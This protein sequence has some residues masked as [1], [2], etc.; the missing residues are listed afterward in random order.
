MR[1]VV[2]S[3]RTVASRGGETGALTLQLQLEEDL[4]LQ[5]GCGHTAAYRL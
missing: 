4:G 3:G 5:P 2:V 1:V